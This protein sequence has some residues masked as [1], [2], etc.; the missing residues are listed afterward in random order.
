MASF[1]H[2]R[3]LVVLLRFRL[4]LLHRGNLLNF[5]LRLILPLLFI[6]IIGRL[7]TFFLIAA[8]SFFL[9]LLL[10]KLLSLGERR[11]RSLAL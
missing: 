3:K 5:L 1:G 6:L 9:I 10:P 2:L 8:T 4:F 11:S 7:P